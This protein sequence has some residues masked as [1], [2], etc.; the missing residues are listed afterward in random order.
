MVDGWVEP[1]GECMKAKSIEEFKLYHSTGNYEPLIGKTTCINLCN[2]LINME[3]GKFEAGSIGICPYDAFFPVPF[4]EQITSSFDFKSCTALDYCKTRLQ[5]LVTQLR[6][7]KHRNTFHF[8]IGSCID[9]CHRNESMWNKFHVIYT[10]DLADRY[11][12]LANLI[13]A[14]LN[15][16][17]IENPQ[18]LLLTETAIW[19][20]LENPTVS[21]FVE[22][23]LGCPLSLVPT[24]YGVRLINHLR[25]G[26][27][28][29][30]KLHDVLY[31]KPVTLQWL[32]APAYSDNVLMG[33]SPAL[34][35]AVE[36][37]AEMC[38]EVPKI[39]SSSEIPSSIPDNLLED[40]F[41]LYS[42]ETFYYVLRS[43]VERCTF[44]PGAAESLFLAAFPPSL[45]LTW[46]TLLMWLNGEPVQLYRTSKMKKAILELLNKMV[47]KMEFDFD[48]NSMPSF[49]LV[50]SL[51][52]KKREPQHPKSNPVQIDVSNGHS[53]DFL[54]WDADMKLPKRVRFLYLS[55]PFF[56]FLLPADHGLEHGT[57][58]FVQ[59]YHDAKRKLITSSM[60]VNFKEF[61][62]EVVINPSP[63][64]MTPRLC[65]STSDATPSIHI[66][67][68]FESADS[69]ELDV[70][71]RGFT[72]SSVNGKS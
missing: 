41:E 11:Y 54:C 48:S 2:F 18:S 35:T 13:P 26:S 16:L 32:R 62:P 46:R 20:K 71:L 61:K 1:F 8:H 63:S 7:R 22:I 4:E 29:C 38:F 52:P 40:F 43:L 66:L 45:Q 5:W 39:L 31:T 9:L 15:C 67:K 24:L 57:R 36:R 60:Y 69:Y 17:S 44:V 50:L 33:I 30:S 14:A 55:E 28:D 23:A 49:D 6:S 51:P 64:M 3:E 65:P 59:S 70:S 53:V 10:F 58:L 47:T 34:K 27:P 42:P 37:L 25:L 72:I 68:C 56:S 12:G 21:E 19:I